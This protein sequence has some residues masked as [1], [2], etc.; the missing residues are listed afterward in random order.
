MPSWTNSP[1]PGYIL[2]N[3]GVMTMKRN[4]A[5]DLLDAA[6][7]LFAELGFENVTIR[8]LVQSTNTNPAAISYYFDNKEHLYQAVLKSQFLPALQVLRQTEAVWLTASEQL[9]RYVKILTAL[10]QKQSY[11][12]ALWQYEM[13]RHSAVSGRFVVKEYTAQLY[14][15][16]VDALC[17]GIS[18]NEFLPDL[19]PASA[20]SVLLEMLHAPYVPA[21][22]LNE[23][24]LADQV[25]LQVYT[26]QAIHYFLRGI[27][28]DPF[29]ITRCA[30]LG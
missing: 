16:L 3:L 8:Q 28:C 6:T 19:E 7:R 12:T 13:R 5:T 24:S 10:Q 29:K 20:A 26:N 30:S 14:Q 21:S 22:L 23:P 1:L 11:L 27:Q 4:T 18:Q 9:L 25:S 17:H 15:Y 2:R